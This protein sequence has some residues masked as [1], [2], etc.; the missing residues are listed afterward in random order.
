MTREIKFRAWDFKERRFWS[1]KEMSELGGFYYYYGVSQFDAD[2]FSLTQFTGLFDK[3]GKEIYEDD[4][5]I[6]N[7]PMY[8]DGNTYNQVVFYNGAFIFKS[9][10][11]CNKLDCVVCEYSSKFIRI[12]GNIYENPELLEVQT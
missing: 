10:N 12:I 7:Q 8:D 6:T 11:N 4:I 9:I 2:E 1:E 5:V 3:N